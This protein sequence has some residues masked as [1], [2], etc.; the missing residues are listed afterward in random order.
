MRVPG[1]LSF[2]IFPSA[3]PVHRQSPVLLIISLAGVIIRK[4]YAKVKAIR[5]QGPAADRSRTGHRKDPDE[6]SNHPR[7]TMFK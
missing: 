5:D 3:D 4:R 7:T 2:L 1:S 6:D